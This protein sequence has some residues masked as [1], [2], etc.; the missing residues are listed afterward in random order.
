MA[1]IL[2][3]VPIRVIAPPNSDEK[4]SGISSLETEIL[5]RREMPIKAGMSIAVA[6]T[7]FINA[8]ITPQ[9]TMIV[10]MRPGSLSPANR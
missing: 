3:G 1:R 6:P 2:A 7:L 4:E 8:E 5:V 9:V 10:A